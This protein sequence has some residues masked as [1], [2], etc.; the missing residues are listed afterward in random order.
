LQDAL[1]S[2]RTTASSAHPHGQ[3]VAIISDAVAERNGV[4]SYYRDLA[5]Q[6]DERGLR[7]E[8]I[9][10]NGH[11]G[12]SLPMPGDSTQRLWLPP[13]RALTARLESLRPKVIVLP[14]PGPFGLYG[15]WAAKRLGA[16]II[17]GFHTHFEALA[18]HYC[19]APLDRPVRL[20]WRLFNARVFRQAT[21]VVTTSR[22]MVTA[23]RAL[24]APHVHRLGTLLGP[25]FIAAHTPNRDQLRSVLFAGRLAAEKN[26]EA[27]VQA[28][29]ELPAVA[30]HI[31]G[32]GPQRDFILHQAGQLP[33][34]HYHG[35]CSRSELLGHMDACDLLVLP[36]HVESFGTVAL[37][38]M[39]RART[40]LISPHCGIAEWPSLAADVAIMQP[41]ES[42]ADAIS[43]LSRLDPRLRHRMAQAARRAALAMNDAALSGWLDIIGDADARQ[44]ADA[45][46]P[47]LTPVHERAMS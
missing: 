26:L 27:V 39:A 30:F 47:E 19:R 36:S 6:L 16:R 38:A 46:C 24:G 42:L 18:R 13:V 34:L 21:G 37:E 3:R 11:S 7:T 1:T 25:E 15:L 31:V 45:V 8:V 33:N 5:V 22:P 43:R 29:H 41:R 35:W 2:E 14:T 23:A 4:G 17:V 44:D 12:R 10:P 9:C 32:D 20:G 28:A 40:A